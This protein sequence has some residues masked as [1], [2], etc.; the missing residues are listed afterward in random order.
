RPRRRRQALRE[1]ADRVHVEAHPRGLGADAQAVAEHVIPPRRANRRGH[2][3]QVIEKVCETWR[4]TGLVI[5]KVMVSVP[6][7]RPSTRTSV[8][9][10]KPGLPSTGETMSPDGRLSC[11]KWEISVPFPVSDPVAV[12][13]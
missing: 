3:G 10:A 11:S 9:R 8:V 6:C 12:M 13:W 5:T 4:C 2:P 7:W 1:V